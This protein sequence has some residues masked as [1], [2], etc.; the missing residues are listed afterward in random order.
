[1]NVRETQV[2]KDICKYITDEDEQDIVAEELE[3]IVINYRDNRGFDLNTGSV[4]GA[5][6][7]AETNNKD[8]WLKISDLEDKYRSDLKETEEDL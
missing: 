5:F 1:M 2:F 3:D 8:F 7:F 6:V 4:L